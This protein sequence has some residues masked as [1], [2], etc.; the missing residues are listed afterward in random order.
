MKEVKDSKLSTS[1]E[2]LKK[3]GLKGSHSYEENKETLRSF[4]D[5]S[6]CKTSKEVH[7]KLVKLSETYLRILQN[8]EQRE[9]LSEIIPSL[10]EVVSCFFDASKYC[11]SEHILET[12]SVKPVTYETLLQ[13]FPNILNILKKENQ[14]RKKEELNHLLDGVTNYKETQEK[15]EGLFK[16]RQTYKEAFSILFPYPEEF[17]I[18]YEF[19]KKKIKNPTLETYNYFTL[20]QLYLNEAI[21]L[22]EKELEKEKETYDTLLR[23]YKDAHKKETILK[24]KE[25][26]YQIEDLNVTLKKKIESLEN[27][28]SLLKTNESKQEEEWKNLILEEEQ[29]KKKPFFVR[30]FQKKKNFEE[31]KKKLEEKK[32]DLKQEL[33]LILSKKQRLET[34]KEKN[35][36]ELS[37][38]CGFSITIEDY[39]NKLNVYER[40]FLSLREMTTKKEKLEKALLKFHIERKEQELNQMKSLKENA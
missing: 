23:E 40:N 30:P 31:E 9:L 18:Y 10:K 27:R 22:K 2:L 11:T 37:N 34:Q 38:I 16:N 12:I 35:E 24:E 3:V 7:D 20:F 28:F 21:L 32:Q 29:E 33:E 8:K 26:F 19:T 6:T 39:R 1:Q 5:L 4:F 36:Q 13:E 17:F 25:N 14:E 15:I